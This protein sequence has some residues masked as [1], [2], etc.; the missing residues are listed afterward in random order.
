M[1]YLNFLKQAIDPHDQVLL[2]FVEQMLP[3]M[4][5]L[6][7]LVDGSAKGGDHAHSTKHNEDTKRKFE[8]K[9]DQSMVS[10]LL[11][12]V[13]ATM[14]MVHILEMER[15][16][17]VPFLD[18]E[19]RIYILSYLMHDVDKFPHVHRIA[20]ESRETIEQA[21]QLIEQELRKC[22]AAEFFPDF[23][24]YLEDITYLVVNTQQKYGTHLHTYLW[25][26][27]LKERRLLLLRR[28][29]T[30]SD[31]IAY[32]VDSPAAIASEAETLITIL[33]ELSDDE[34]EFTY[35]Q[36]REV[37]GLLTNVINNGLV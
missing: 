11:N 34:L 9:N 26:L 32:L 33:A 20:T 28:L 36:M 37:R 14:R 17:P 8:E 35:H 10:H 7:Y 27:Q 29:C 4:M 16:G 24:D 19:R 2:S 15:L 1:F 30:Y 5:E 23:V 6:Q 13:F 3:R 31:H 25:K 21:K 12:G 22:G 18:V